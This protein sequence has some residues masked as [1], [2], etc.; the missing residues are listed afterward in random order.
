MM[1]LLFLI[2]LNLAS[3]VYSRGFDTQLHFYDPDLTNSFDW[4]F[5]QE[6]APQY[7]NVIV[8]PISLKLILGLLYQGS[9]SESEKEFQ[10]ILNYRNK[11]IVKEKYTDI[12]N[13][14]QNAERTEYLLNIGTAI[15]LDQDLRIQ[16][17]FE[18][19]SRRNF[20]TDIRATNFNKPKQASSMINEWI[21]NLTNGKITK[22]IDASDIPQT[23]MV[24]TNVLYFKG[25]WT[26][27]FPKNQTRVGT[28]LTTPNIKRGVPVEY[29]TTSD[30]FLY[31]ED[32][33]LNCKVLRLEYRDSSFVMFILLPNK[34]GGLDD[35]IK[36]VDLSKIGNIRFQMTQET[37][38]VT[39]PK[40]KFNFDVKL[41]PILRKFGFHQIFDNMT[42]LTGIIKNN[43]T[44]PKR[45][46]V[47]D[48][49]QKSGI[50][51]DEEG[52][53]IYSATEFNVG[54]KFAE[55]ILTFNASHPFMFFIEGPNN[56]IL[57]VGKCEDPSDSWDSI[58]SNN[59]ESGKL[60]VNQSQYVVVESKYNNPQEN[61]NNVP[62]LN[63]DPDSY[64]PPDDDITQLASRFNLFDVELLG[65]FKYSPVN[66][67]IS[68]A[69][70]K[71]TLAMILEGA[72]GS[73][74]LEI[75]EALR[76]PDINLKATR[77]ILQQLVNNLNEKATA[78]TFL[79]YH[80]AVFTSDKERLLEDYKNVVMKF[81]NAYLK[82]LDF[83]NAVQAAK[84][85][86]KWV[87]DSTRGTIDR[88]ISEEMISPESYIIISNALYFK[89][90]WKKSFDIKSTMK[91]CFY[92]NK[93]CVEV[94]MMHISDNFNYNYI[95]TL[96]AYVV[97]IPYEDK[98]SMLLIL[99]TANA[100]VRTVI[101]D[102]PH[103]MST[104][105]NNLMTSEIVLELPRFSFEYSVDLTDN[106]KALNVRDIFGTKANLS[107]IVQG[108]D[109]KVNRLLHKTKIMVDE[110]GTTASA[111]TNAMII[112][113]MQP[114]TITVNRPFVFMIYHRD[115]KNIIFEGIIQNPLE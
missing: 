81:Y 8:S 3:Q 45:L 17:N 91:K 72:V 70:V 79:E 97:D 10:R 21:E 35:L 67:L 41:A 37:V 109:A 55:N 114:I 71:T 107:R 76:I 56:T 65:E 39:I 28:F 87:S 40:F 12:L 52:S 86:N 78:N 51:V 59:Y 102:L 69:S 54:N 88:I 108:K 103:F 64:Q 25:T 66:V 63:L 74:A 58:N 68:P 104:I 101:R 20:R 82:S 4:S 43:S 100:N 5:L 6:L 94:H 27:Q 33:K 85:I 77:T 48:I 95:N 30:E 7:K 1:M 22:I 75:S 38:R 90:K 53:V 115:T 111:S 15:F 73:C 93:G 2:A 24:I 89:G 16:P 18:Q 110:E 29:M 57:F 113:L 61:L 99:P 112:P 50:E 14:L 34:L 36:N 62:T 96:R 60:E 98:F 31:Y 26:H 92:T 42:S 83:T 46:F 49:V 84:V 44:I 105:L 32:S 23:L 19:I 13:N 47:N 106:L 80:N 9:E 11:E